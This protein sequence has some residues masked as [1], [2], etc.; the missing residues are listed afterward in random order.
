MSFCEV[1]KI[2]RFPSSATS[3]ALMDISLPTK[4][5]STIYGKTT[6]SLIGSNGIFLGISIDCWRSMLFVSVFAKLASC[7]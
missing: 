3:I 7:I 6:I 5:G 2:M 1:R 4:S